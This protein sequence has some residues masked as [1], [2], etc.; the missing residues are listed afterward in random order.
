MTKH[1][2]SV[3]EAKGKF[4]ELISRAA[5]G[6]R[7]VIHR[8]N[9]PVAVLVSPGDLETLTRQTRTALSLARAA[10]QR[11]AILAGIT[12]GEL[13]PAMAAFGLA[14]DDA[15]W[16]RLALELARPRAGKIRRKPITL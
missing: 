6:E 7:F 12:A 16:A 4:S 8:R 11:E 2:I 13:H 3:G 15:E 14:S 5:A 9:K 10:G 1:D